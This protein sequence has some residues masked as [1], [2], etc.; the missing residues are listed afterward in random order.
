MGLIVISVVAV[1][2]III[3]GLWVEGI[4][5]MNKKYPDYKGEEFLGED[6]EKKED[7]D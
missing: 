3:V 2:F 4:D 6:E 7:N 1:A 5:Q